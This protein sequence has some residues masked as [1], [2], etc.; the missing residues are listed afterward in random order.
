[1]GC[2]VSKRARAL[3][4]SASAPREVETVVPA[5]S[6]ITIDTQG[7]DWSACDGHLVATAPW[8]T[9]LDGFFVIDVRDSPTVWWYSVGEQTRVALASFEHEELPGYHLI[10]SLACAPHPMGTNAKERS[11]LDYTLIVRGLGRMHLLNL[12]ELAVVARIDL[13]MDENFVVQDEH[14]ILTETLLPCRRRLYRKLY[15]AHTGQLLSTAHYNLPGVVYGSLRL[16]G[17]MQRAQGSRLLHLIVGEVFTSRL[18]ERKNMAPDYTRMNY[19]L[20]SHDVQC[21][22]SG[23]ILVS[24]QVSTDLVVDLREGARQYRLHRGFWRH[25]IAIDNSGRVLQRRHGEQ[26]ALTLSYLPTDERIHADTKPAAPRISA[27]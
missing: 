21:S 11:Y 20:F 6:M 18:H 10:T 22:P 5:P 27:C 23:H 12:R 1:M 24:D 14:V 3:A 2:L 4:G 7:F 9:H 13:G 16:L 17:V 15:H 25:T 26:H 19:A 8:D